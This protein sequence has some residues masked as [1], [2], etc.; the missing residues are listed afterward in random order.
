MEMLTYYVLLKQKL[1]LLF[2][3]VSFLLQGITHRIAQ[4]SVIEVLGYYFM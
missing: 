4:V 3:P 1:T 2:Q